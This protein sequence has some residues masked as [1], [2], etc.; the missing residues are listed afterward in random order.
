MITRSDLE[1]KVKYAKLARTLAE[2]SLKPPSVQFWKGYET[3]L[4]DLLQIE[5]FKDGV[6]D[7]V[8]DVTEV[9][10]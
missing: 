2:T 3:A 5:I 7:M 4:I 10:A 8:R 6:P 1:A 9:H